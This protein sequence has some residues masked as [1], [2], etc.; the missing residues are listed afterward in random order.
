MNTGSI[1]TV[2]ESPPMARPS[3]RKKESLKSKGSTPGEQNS[4]SSVPNHPTMS[5]GK[6]ILITGSLGLTGSACVALFK[7]KGWEVHGL[8]N[9]Q[10]SALFGTAPQM[11]KGGY[12]HEINICDEKGIDELFSKYKWDAII[13][14]AAQPSH[15]WA[16][17][18]VKEDFL[19]NAWGT[20][21]LLEATR[22]HC[23]EAVF[24]H[25]ST[26]KVYGENMTRAGL[27][28]METRYE[29]PFP[30]R[31]NL[32][33]DFAGRRSLF[34]CSKAS[35][36]IYAQE[37]ANYFGMKVGIFRP[38]CITGKNHQGAELHGFLSY[39]AK[40]IKD[41]KTYK[42][43][44]F[45]GK[46]VRDQIHAEDVASAFAAFID[47][48]RTGEVYNIGGGPERSISVLEAIQL[49]EV[50]TGKKAKVEFHEERPGDR[51]WDV[52]DMTRFC[53]HY[54]NWKMKYSLQDIIRDL[55]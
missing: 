23:P 13:H 52:H 9:N 7:E 41:E 24:V 54:P 3:K 20:L 51:I 19:I 18:H 46:Q 17:D 26:D 8:D 48:P 12:H 16:K 22:T 43:F 32:G 44:G 47:S 11:A 28:E 2:T 33:L 42:V 55:I 36:D 34:G 31:E 50:A 4:S 15:D 35:S 49:L 29:H 14:T 38:G 21:V 10:R 25:M 27:L 6:K 39:L 37:Y 45:K 40:C 53:S 1:L 5:S 30:F